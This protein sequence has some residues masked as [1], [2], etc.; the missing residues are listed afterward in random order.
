MQKEPVLITMLIVAL[1]S[2]VNIALTP[3]EQAGLQYI[4]EGAILAGGS[5]YARSQ[6]A[7]KA[8]VSEKA[9]NTTYERI[10]KR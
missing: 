8:S 4:V 2:A 3:E 7:S 10:F 9:D 1:L 5:L 6:V